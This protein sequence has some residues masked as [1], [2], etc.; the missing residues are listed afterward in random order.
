[1]GSENI[2]LKI[3]YWLIQNFEYMFKRI[4]AFYPILNPT[5]QVKC[6]II[7]YFVNQV[8]KF[9]NLISLNNK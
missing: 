4:Y 2:N 7:V 3:L 6:F 8:Q 5:D 9:F 1:M